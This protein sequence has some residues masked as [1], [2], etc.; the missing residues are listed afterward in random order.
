M[1]LS[2]HHQLPVTETLHIIPGVIGVPSWETSETPL[3]QSQSLQGGRGVGKEE[4]EG[5]EEV[6]IGGEMTAGRGTASKF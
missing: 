2:R 4:E 5:L 6:E 3:K 1:S